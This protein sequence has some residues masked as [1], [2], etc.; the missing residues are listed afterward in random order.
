M[1]KEHGRTGWQRELGVSLNNVGRIHEGL[2]NVEK[3]LEYYRRALE[4]RRWLVEK[5]PEVADRH[6]GLAFALLDMFRVTEDEDKKREFMRE[7]RSIAK[8]LVDSGISHHELNKL[9]K[10]FS[11]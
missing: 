3:A 6:V 1:K 8:A 9:K 5:E 7:A 11:L 10:I 4:I 2:G